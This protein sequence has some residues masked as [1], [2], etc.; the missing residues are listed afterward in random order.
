MLPQP[1]SYQTKSSGIIK[2]RM[3]LYVYSTQL[4]KNW[5]ITDDATA[6][7][8]VTKSLGKLREMVEN[9]VT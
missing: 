7:L 3:I 6:K 5:W 1:I 8:C 4:G 2:P 9:L